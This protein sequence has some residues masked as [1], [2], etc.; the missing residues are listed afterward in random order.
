MKKLLLVALLFSMNAAFAQFYVSASGGYSIGSA[1]ILTGTSLNSS[2]T[3]AEN[4]YGSYG[5]GFNLQLRGGYYFNE[6]F[7][8]ELALGYLSGSDQNISSYLTND[9][10]DIKEYT[11]GNAHAEAYGINIALAYNFNENFYGKIGM[12]S[13]LG[14]KTEATFLKSTPT[15]FG[16][17]V[18]EGVNDYHGRPPLGFT[19]AF[20]YKYKLSDNWNLFA[21]L[22]YLGINVTR[23]TSEFAELTITTPDVPGNAFYQ[24][25]PA[26]PSSTWNLG[27]APYLWLSEVPGLPA[28]NIV[29]IYAPSEIE[30][31]DTL[32]E[33]N[34]D[35][36][37]ALS[38][39]AP[40]SSFGL[41]IGITYTFSKKASK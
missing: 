19:A 30:Y 21:E 35:P 17:I 23:D 31:V 29:P 12:V 40:Y 33:P 32:P 38:S 39:V 16:E 8:V 26:V 34:N 41:N 15:P 14:G 25:S 1:G 20:G 28:E 22:E 36:S 4:H 9:D 5:E 11:N 7:G 37:K 24:G 6:M 10:G 2:Q 13:K 18:A 3:E 27:D